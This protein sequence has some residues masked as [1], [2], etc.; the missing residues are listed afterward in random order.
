MPDHPAPP[1]PPDTE[2]QSVLAA[3]ALLVGRRQGP[4]RPVD[5]SGGFGE[6]SAR[7]DARRRI[8]LSRR[9]P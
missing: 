5:T 4:G 6:F 9:A 7:M 1:F 3:Q 2:D 8:I